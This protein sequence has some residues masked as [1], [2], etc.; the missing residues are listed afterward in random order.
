VALT[1]I[2]SGTCGHSSHEDR[3]QPSRRLRH[4]VQARSNRCTAYG[5]G[6]PAA[7]C[8]LDHTTPYDD[9]GR[10][11]EC[12]LAPLCRWHHQ[13]KQAQGWRLDQPEPGILIWTS[14]AGLT[15]RTTPTSYDN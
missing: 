5:C 8:D 3:Y 15:R 12:G 7:A 13:V 11:C 10:T 9:G 4:L 14:P 1:P 2:A 6:R